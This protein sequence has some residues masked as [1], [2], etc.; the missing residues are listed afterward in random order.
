MAFLVTIFVGCGYKEP[1]LNEPYGILH[2]LGSLKIVEI[3][4]E[5][6]M[7]FSGD[8]VRRVSPGTHLLTLNYGTNEQT[9]VEGSKSPIGKLSVDV[10]EGMRYYLAAEYNYEKRDMLVGLNLSV[11]TSWRPVLKKTEPIEGYRTS[12]N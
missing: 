1:A 2:P 5:H 10:E 12:Q 11:I 4:D 6:V 8:Y 3:D 7:S 9:P